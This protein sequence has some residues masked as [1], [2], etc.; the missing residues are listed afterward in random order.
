MSDGS[1]AEHY[2]TGYEQYRLG[3]GTSAIEFVRTKELLQRFLPPPP[4]TVLD[5][6]GGPGAMPR[7]WL[8]SGIAFTSSTP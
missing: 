5:V 1:L 6:G 7:G 2:R 4:A 3:K 8:I